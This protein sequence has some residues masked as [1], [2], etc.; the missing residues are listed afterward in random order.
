M[1]SSSYK[2]TQTFTLTA[3]LISIILLFSF[4]PFGYIN[5]GIIKAT[6][7]QIPVILGSILLGPRIG[8]LLGTFF[9]VT[10]LLVNTLSPSVL[11]F[12]FSPFIPVLGTQHGSP[13][14]LFICFVPRILVGLL[15]YYIYTFLI[16]KNV[17]NRLTLILTGLSGSMINTLLVMNL[18]YIIFKYQYSAARNLTAGSSIY[19]AILAVIAING[20]PEAIITAIVITLLTP[21]LLKRLKL[22]IN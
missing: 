19:K 18:I 14:A 1:P 17:S 6:L 12:A 22:S 5:L 11:S 20:V 9:G 3:I 2:K 21:I 15:P 4:T 13:W 7:V 8:M 10:S 16:K